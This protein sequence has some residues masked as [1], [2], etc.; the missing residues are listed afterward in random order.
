MLKYQSQ[1]KG[2]TIIEVV[3]VLAIGGLIMM[4]ALVALPGLQRSQ[5][6]TARREDMLRL[7]TFFQNYQSNNRSR[8]PTGESSLSPAGVLTPEID[9]TTGYSVVPD[10]DGSTWD[11]FYNKYILNCSGTG[12]NMVCTDVFEDPSG[13][14]YGIVINEC[15]SNKQQG[16]KCTLQSEDLLFSSD[17]SAPSLDKVGS[18]Q[19][20]NYYILVTRNATCDGTTTKYVSGTRKLA[21]SYKYEGAGTFCQDI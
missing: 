13:G 15:T 12:D 6:D 16:Q 5:R 18:A 14:P 4:M 3:L 19:G 7:V 9:D 21:I 20:Q 8:L 2:F 10:V 17:D 11:E 1:K